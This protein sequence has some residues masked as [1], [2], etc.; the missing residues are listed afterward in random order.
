MH[1]C[2]RPHLYPRGKGCATAWYSCTRVHPYHERRGF[3]SGGLCQPGTTA[4]L[5]SFPE[6]TP[7]LRV[8][9]PFFTP[10]GP[11]LSALSSTLHLP[12]P[13]LL[14]VPFTWSSP[15]NVHQEIPFPCTVLGN[16]LL[17]LL[18]LCFLLLLYPLLC[19]ILSPT[20]V[21]FPPLLSLQPSSIL[22]GPALFVVDPSKDVQVPSAPS[23]IQRGGHHHQVS[24]T[25]QC[26]ISP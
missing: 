2:L 15:V 3:I 1:S 17:C 21:F 13:Q 14:L 18:L 16:R 9:S 5:P 23:V 22:Q 26:A 25:G 4:A 6:D 20:T 24:G 7:G 19:S 11:S 8:P 10:L 12:S